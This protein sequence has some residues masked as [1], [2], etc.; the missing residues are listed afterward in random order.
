MNI[1]QPTVT[2]SLVGIITALSTAATASLDFT[3]G[4][5]FT[6]TLSS[7]YTMYLNPTNIQAGQTV[8]LK[9]TQPATSGSLTYPSSLKFPGGIPY[10]ASSTGSAVDIL[11]FVTFDTT[12][13][14]TTA[15]KNVS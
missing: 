6:L 13:L 9:V 15:I 1:Y 10:T 5:F 7:S 4:S 14:Y 3:S 2:G 8:I 11:T 12:T